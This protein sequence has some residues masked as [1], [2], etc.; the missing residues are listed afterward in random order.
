[1]LET[2]ATA[3]FSTL[4]DEEDSVE[5]AELPDNVVGLRAL[6]A[7]QHEVGGAYEV[8]ADA[9]PLE[10]S[11]ASRKRTMWIASAM[12]FAFLWLLLMLLAR[13]ASGMPAI[14]RR[15][16]ASALPPSASPTACWRRAPSKRSRA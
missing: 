2:K 3:E 5:A 13:N 10:A 12:L 14:R 15:A 8:Y 4:S 9:E 1:M 11:I 16:S 7:G 6:F